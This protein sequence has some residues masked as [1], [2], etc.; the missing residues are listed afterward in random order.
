M[1]ISYVRRIIQ[2]CENLED[3]QKIIT[4]KSDKRIFI[5]TARKNN[6]FFLAVIITQT[7]NYRFKLEPNS[8]IKI[9]K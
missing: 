1:T 4:K 7:I 6:I 9:N 8:T 5:I 2:T 3:I